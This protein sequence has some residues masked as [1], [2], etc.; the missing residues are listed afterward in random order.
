M[1]FNIPQIFKD[2]EVGEEGKPHLHAE[3]QIRVVLAIDRDKAVLPFEC[4]NTSWK[5]I[6]HIP[7]NT[8]TKIN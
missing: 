3:Q 2:G 5:S 4:G 1:D 6:L 7:E 8:S